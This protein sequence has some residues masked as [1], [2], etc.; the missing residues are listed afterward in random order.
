MKIRNLLCASGDRVRPVG[1]APIP[2]LVALLCGQA[3]LF[4]PGCAHNANSPP[5]QTPSQT[6][7]GW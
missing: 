7:G 4:A 1:R 5:S 6:G 2:V 3:M